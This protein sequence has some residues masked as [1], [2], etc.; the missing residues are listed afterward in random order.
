MK[1]KDIKLND[2]LSLLEKEFEKSEGIYSE[3]EKYALLNAGKRLRP[4]LMFLICREI[5]PETEISDILPAAASI[6]CIHN[7]SLVHDDL[8]CMDND[9][10]RRGKPSAHIKFGEANAV[11]LGDRL[12]SSAFRYSSLV[13]YESVRKILADSSLKMLDG[14][15]TDVNRINLVTEDDFLSMYE[16]KTG[17]LIYA[18]F[19]SGYLIANEDNKGE[20]FKEIE[21]LALSFGK[22]FQ[23]YDDLSDHDEL[24]MYKF[25]EETVKKYFVLFKDRAIEIS[26]KLGLTEINSYLNRIF[27]SKM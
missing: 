12:L 14:Q 13:K 18:S 6:E 26:E 24:S 20:A 27:T 2:F 4:S 19:V 15:Y 8:P 22:A 10:L 21:E 3:M 16:N 5:N 25:G 11:L 23:L 1:L 17:A 7:Y 9:D